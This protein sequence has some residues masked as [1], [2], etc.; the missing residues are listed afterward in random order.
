MGENTYCELSSKN[1]PDIV[2]RLKDVGEQ[3]PICKE[4]ALEIQRLQRINEHLLEI[5]RGMG[6]NIQE[7][8]RA[9]ESK[10]QGNR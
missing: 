10:S 6:R 5:L 9:H 4:A 8:V 1:Q 2:E 7:I 3:L